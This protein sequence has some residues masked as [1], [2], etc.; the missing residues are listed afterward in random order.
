M[1]TADAD[2]PVLAVADAA[3]LHE[4]VATAVANKTRLEVVGS[5]SR[6]DLGRPVDADAV[7]DLAGL[8]GITLY[9][10]DELVMTARAATPLADIVTALDDAGQV[11]AFDPPLRPSGEMR[12][13]GT[14]GGLMA[15]NQSG[16]RRLVAGAA[17]DYLLGFKAV[18]GRGEGF[19]SGSRVMKNVTGY[20]LS[21]LMAGSFGTLAVMHELT[22]KTMP[23][24][25]TAATVLH[26]C[27]DAATA[28]KLVSA[29]YASPHE[30]SMAAMIPVATAVFSKSAV[31]ADYAQKG[32]IVAVRLEG[33]ETS[34][35]A[36]SKALADPAIGNAV[37]QIPAGFITS[38]E[39]SDIIHEELREVS[40]LPRQNN[41]VIWKISCPP[42]TGG[43]L[44]D[45]LLA[46]PNCRAYADWAGGLIWLSHPSGGDGGAQAIRSMVD[47][48]GGHAMLVT[49]PDEM[50]R[51]GDVFPPQDDVLMKLTRRIKAGFDP[52]G[53]LNPGRMYEGV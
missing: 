32:T 5:G 4:A 51:K 13:R 49:A 41:R 42:E 46:R 18:S 3:A 6:R 29:V 25:E 26:I 20:D 22:L 14:I 7:I 8:A 52:E 31:F 19:Q 1:A 11:L 12:A 34:V 47:E 50:R 16:P 36:R 43:R 39:D 40:L 37:E 48:T 23:K 17:R 9:E 53:I 30:A 15:T 28:Q 24:P 27:P 38:A 2:I 44:L 45:A 35:R 33:F 21:K 10:P